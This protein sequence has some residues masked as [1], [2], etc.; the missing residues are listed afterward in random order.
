MSLDI[1]SYL[2]G[3]QS[4]GG[5]GG[6]SSSLSGLTDVGI[7]N[8][9]D[10]QTLVY[11]STS[12][13]WENGAGGLPAPTAA[14]VDKVMSVVATPVPGAVIVPEQTATYMSGAMPPSYL[15][16]NDGY[17]SIFKPGTMVIVNVDIPN[18]PNLM[19]ISVVIASESTGG[20]P[21]AIG[22]DAVTG[23]EIFFGIFP[24]EGIFSDSVGAI[25]LP[26][27]NPEDAPSTVTVSCSVVAY[28][29]SWQ[30]ESYIG[31]DVVVKL[32]NVIVS[33]SLSDSDLHLMKGSVEECDRKM[34]AGQPITALV[35]YN[36]IYYGSAGQFDVR[37]E[38]Y[39]TEVRSALMYGNYVELRIKAINTSNTKRIY[40]TESGLTLTD[41]Y[42]P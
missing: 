36:D 14:D 35:Y 9:T 28:T 3:R 29:Y 27:L 21:T 25:V 2:L 8:P 13:K 38:I 42:Q 15:F 26:G 7:S 11:N 34:L 10:G 20:I 12:G 39:T 16:P 19:A 18:G 22:T 32:D 4:G 6:G 31:Y 37:S 17:E 24:A 1:P 33:P 41:Q 30:P 40:L 5:G 23:E